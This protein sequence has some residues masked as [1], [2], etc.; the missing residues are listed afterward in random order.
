MCS[1]RLLIA[2]ISIEMTGFRWKNLAKHL[3]RKAKCRVNDKKEQ[4]QFESLLENF[5][6]T[7]KTL[8]ANQNPNDFKEMENVAD[9]I[10][11]E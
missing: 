6:P 3:K 10:M 9:D 4:C 7:I 8:S 11:T 2:R 1:A 5:F